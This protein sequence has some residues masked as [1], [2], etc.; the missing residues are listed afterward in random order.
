VDGEMAAVSLEIGIGA[1]ADNRHAA[2]PSVAIDDED[3]M[4]ASSSGIRS[5]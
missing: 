2:R 1:H 4:I 5:P 3:V